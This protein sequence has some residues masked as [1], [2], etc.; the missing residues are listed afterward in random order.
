MKRL[1]LLG[2]TGSVGLRTLEVVSSFPEE[3]TVAGLAARGSNVERVADLCRKYSPRAVALLEPAAIDRL[4]A[5]LPHPRPE[6]LGGPAGLIA[7]ARDVDADMVLSALVSIVPRD[8]K[9]T[10]L[11]R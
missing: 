7:L 2:C 9:P 4:A 10:R 1:T 5:L 6:L 11:R 3:F 8:V